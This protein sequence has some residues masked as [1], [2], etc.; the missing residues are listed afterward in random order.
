MLEAYNI[1]FAYPQHAPLFE[2]L[3]LCVLPDERVALS[4][5]SGFGKTTL[6]KILSG[7]L[8]PTKGTV[9][10]DDK[11]LLVKG[12]SPVQLIWQHPE[13]VV[14][15]RLRLEKTLSEAGS[16]SLDLLERLG[17]RQ[18]WLGRYP[19]ELS[20]GELQRICI[21]RALVTNPR[22]LIADEMT[23]MLDAVTQARIWKVLL[24]EVERAHI[25]LIFVSHAPALSQRIA[26]RIVTLG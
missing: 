2:N 4:A 9:S 16:Y 19:H 7:Y 11:P 21:A 23:T 6:A 22:Y 18:E 1:S 20:G 17:I 25:G 8:A 26:T 10:C 13:M 12:F 24:E 14:D 15:P 3:N 5:P